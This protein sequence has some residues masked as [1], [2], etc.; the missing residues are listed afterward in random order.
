MGTGPLAPFS[1]HGC[2]YCVE[3]YKYLSI[4]G[5]I[6]V[7]VCKIIA[8]RMSSQANGI[9]IDSFPEAYPHLLYLAYLLTKWNNIP[10]NLCISKEE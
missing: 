8:Y 7:E 9:R 6:V 10:M 3:L 2:W 1:I 4:S 5:E